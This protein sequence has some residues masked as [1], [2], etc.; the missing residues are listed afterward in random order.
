MAPSTIPSLFS[1]PS[2]M[3]TNSVGYSPTP[4]ERRKVETWKAVK[5]Y[6]GLYE[7]SDLGR[8][9]SVDRVVVH[10]AS[11]R[12]APFARKL[13]GRI[14]RLETRP[15]GHLRVM[16]GNKARH[17]WVHHL[18]ADAFG[19]LGDGPIIRHLDGNP[20]N[21][22]PNNLRRGTHKENST[23]RYVH[24]TV[25]RGEKSGTAKVSVADVVAIRLAH[26][27]GA[28]AAGLARKYGINK[29]TAWRILNRET[30]KHAA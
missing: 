21:N 4:T 26:A 8:V 10:P 11:R 15:T 1:N 28:G 6:E 22:R 20:K 17:L 29:R 5:G 9:R 23:D 3:T 19:I 18:V 13:K 2:T 16:L 14:L 25:P 24:G 27:S 12:C 7:V 30:W